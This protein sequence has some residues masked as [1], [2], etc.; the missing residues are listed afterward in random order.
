MHDFRRAA[1]VFAHGAFVIVGN[2]AGRLTLVFGLSR[3]L[4]RH[5][6]VPPLPAA[7]IGLSDRNR[8]G[9]CFVS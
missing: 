6:A 7:A 3:I 1:A 8:L 5:S 4:V 9:A 2:I